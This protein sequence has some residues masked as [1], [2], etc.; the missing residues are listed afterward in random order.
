[1]EVS[2]T[3]YV[4]LG[5]LNWRPRTGYEIKQLVD[6]STRFFWAAS[7]GQIYPELKRLE[8]DGLVSGRS[9]PQGGRK[10]RVYSLT[11]KGRGELSAWLERPPETFET[12][13]EG[14]LK[15]FFASADEP[16]G[17]VRQLREMR[18]NSEEIVERLREIEH[19][20]ADPEG[21]R[22]LCLRYGIEM[23][24]WIA[25]WCKRQ[26]REVTAANTGRKAA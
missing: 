1:M 13:T 17:V 14:L 24:E 22:P 4:V 19:D 25:E 11:A 2:P 21:F 6:R 26:E 16:E 3:G 15:L 12:R 8:K 9:D 5:I 7:Y 18:R 23:N 20:V 10:R